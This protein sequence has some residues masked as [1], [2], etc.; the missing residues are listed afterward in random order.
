M[1][2]A[3]FHGKRQMWADKNG[4][5]VLAPTGYPYSHFEWFC[6]LFGLEH[7]RHWMLNCTRGYYFEDR[8]VA[9]RGE[10]FAVLGCDI[11]A[12]ETAVKV[13]SAL[14]GPVLEVGLGALPG[15]T[16][17]WLPRNLTPAEDFTK[18]VALWRARKE[19]V[20]RG[21]QEPT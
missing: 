21:Q 9:Y 3:E 1:T 2:E 19:W 13:F 11:A 12:V 5:F 15:K 20:R 4:H 16:Q 6:G 18:Q 7:A 10:D 17:P 14:Y 8:V